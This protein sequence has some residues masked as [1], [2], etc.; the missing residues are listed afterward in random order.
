VQVLGVESGSDLLEAFAL[1][2]QP[3]AG[4]VGLHR[5]RA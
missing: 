4:V 3:V 2:G 1:F 5:G